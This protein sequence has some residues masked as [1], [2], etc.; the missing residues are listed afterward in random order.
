MDKDIVLGELEHSEKNQNFGYCR[1]IKVDE[2]LHAI[3]NMSK[4][5]MTGPDEMPME[6]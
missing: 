1:Y 2:V 4:G 6:F 5:K 3:S